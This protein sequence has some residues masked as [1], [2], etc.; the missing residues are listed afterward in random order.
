M[1]EIYKL[2]PAILHKFHFELQVPEWKVKNCWFRCPSD[3]SVKVVK[4]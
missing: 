3:V 1:I 2:L 4:R